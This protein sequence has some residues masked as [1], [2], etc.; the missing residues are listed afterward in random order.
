MYKFTLATK[1]PNSPMLIPC[2]EGVSKKFLK[3]FT[4]FSNIDFKGEM[5]E[6]LG[7]FHKE[8]SKKII[9][10]GIGIRNKNENI[11]N[12]VKKSIFAFIKNGGRVA[13]LVSHL[14]NNQAGQAVFGAG[15]ANYDINIYKTSN[16]EKKEL[17]IVVVNSDKEFKTQFENN[18]HFIKTYHEVMDLVNLPSNIKTPYYLADFSVKSG[19]EHGF[20]VKVLKGEELVKAGLH[21]V[22][23]VGKASHNP[24]AFIVMEYTPSSFKKGDDCVGL[25][26]KGV[27][28]D[29]GGVSIKPSSNMHY[30]KSDMAGA[31]AVI[32]V[33]QMAAKLKINKR[34]VGIV[35]TAE[36]AVGGRAYRPG[37]VISSYSGKS[38]EVIDTDAEGRLLL[39][40]GLSYMVK[41]FAPE[42]M[43]DLATLTGS[44]VATLG[45]HAAGI[46]TQND[47]LADEF[48]QSGIASGEKVWRLPMWDEY[49]SY[50]NSDIAD[51]K[52]LS[53]VPV[54]GATTAAKFLEFFTEDHKSWIHLDVA[55]VVF[56]DN[57]IHKSRIATG[58]GVKLIMDWLSKK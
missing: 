32:G 51:I 29:T 12:T 21:A 33:M 20:K 18:L 13:L 56:T 3:E 41:N 27:S 15:L 31:A 54:A 4:G 34:V 28:F 42:S 55:G 57:D 58:F 53:S 5:G 25:I 6:T 2:H 50:M 47:A 19:K 16:E 48:Y 43:I 30:M 22:Y 40:D 37:D 26:G 49:K 44:C 23:E 8:N 7:L 10:V 52:N 39:A 24:P 14:D 1:A 46:F 9:L 11:S 35:P 36:N 38:I 45:S 17:E